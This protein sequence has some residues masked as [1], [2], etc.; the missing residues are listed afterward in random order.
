[1]ASLPQAPLGL[2]CPLLPGSWLDRSLDPC[3]SCAEPDK[4]A[5]SSCCLG[6]ITNH[7]N[8]VQQLDKTTI[9]RQDP[10]PCRAVPGRGVD[11]PLSPG[12]HRTRLRRT[13]CVEIRVSRAGSGS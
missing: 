7:I 5:L 4:T 12:D 9:L 6:S 8:M 3:L 10:V 2:R 11:G 1:M 13:T